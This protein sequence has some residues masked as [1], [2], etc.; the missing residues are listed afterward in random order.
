MNA[1]PKTVA[2]L[3]DLPIKMAGNTPIYVRDV[4]TVSDSFSPQT[5]IVRLDGERG[6][7]I[8]VLKQGNASTLDVVE[9][10]RNL[11]PKIA[12]TLPPELKI[13]PLA[14]QSL[15]VRRRNRRRSTRGSDRS[16][17]DRVHDPDVS[18]ELAQHD[19]HRDLDSTLDPGFHLRAQRHRSDHQ[20]HDAGRSRACR[21]HPR[22]RCD[23]DD[24][25]HQ[26]H[27]PEEGRDLHTAILEGAAQIA[28][29]ALVSTLCICIV[30]LPM[31]FL[32]G[33]ARYLFI[34]LA[35]AVVF[36]ML[37]SYILSR[38]LVP[39]LASYLLRAHDGMFRPTRNP[40]KMMQQAFERGFERLRLNYQLLL[41]T[42]IYRRFVFV[43]VFLVLCLC[44][45][46]LFP[47]LGQDFFPTSDNGQIR[48]HFRTKTGTRIEETARL[49]DLIDQ[50]IRRQIPA[51]ELDSIG[52]DNM[53]L[54]SVQQY[55]HHV[56]QQW[57][58]RLRRRGRSDLS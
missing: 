44:G 16:L 56:Q 12:A 26:S 6:A 9:G 7:L 53:G 46:L 43:P 57:R 18:R 1:S 30:F 36:A 22:R 49:C 47:W 33:V 38:T 25:K 2:E 11:L 3:N 50:S 23:G 42:C 40:F 55:Q 41:T 13:Q 17:P 32:S 58:D 54:P 15:F 10:V 27:S 52:I 39:T 21:R 24:R 45:F 28:V 5:N 20:H 51:G 48:L 37:A 19:H 14:D 8:S 34:P 4:A 35:E 29:P 31:F